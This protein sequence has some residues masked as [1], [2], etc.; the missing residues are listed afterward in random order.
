MEKNSFIL[1]FV[2]M[3]TQGKANVNKKW[4]WIC[5]LDEF[6]PCE[7]GSGNVSRGTKCITVVL[8][9]GST[10]APNVTLQCKNLPW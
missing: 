4:N 2:N 1:K 6:L 5:C 3:K 8:P 10:S 7:F 9:K